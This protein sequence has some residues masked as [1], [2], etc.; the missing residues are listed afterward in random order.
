MYVQLGVKQV[1]KQR[2]DPYG[3]DGRTRALKLLN[4][5]S[6]RACDLGAFVTHFVKTRDSAKAFQIPAWRSLD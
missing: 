5:S 6:V 2:V 3:M 4:R 1:R